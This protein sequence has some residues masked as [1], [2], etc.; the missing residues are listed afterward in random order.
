[1]ENGPSGERQGIVGVGQDDLGAISDSQPRT[2]GVINENIEELLQDLEHHLK[3]GHKYDGF[4][5]VVDKEAANLLLYVSKT[6]QKLWDVVI[7]INQNASLRENRDRKYGEELIPIVARLL[8]ALPNR[9]EEENAF[10]HVYQSTRSENFR[11]PG[12]WVDDA[13]QFLCLDVIDEGLPQNGYYLYFSSL[14]QSASE[15]I[16]RLKGLERSHERASNDAAEE[17]ILK[18]MHKIEVQINHSFATAEHQCPELLNE[19]R[20]SLGVEASLKPLVLDGYAEFLERLDSLLKE[21]VLRKNKEQL[22]DIPILQDGGGGMQHPAIFNLENL[23]VDENLLRSCFVAYCEVR[24][25]L[26]KAYH[27]GGTLRTIDKTVGL[28]QAIERALRAPGFLEPL[29]ASGCEVPGALAF[30][31]SVQPALRYTEQ[32]RM[33]QTYYPLCEMGNNL[34]T[35][36]LVI[37][38]YLTSSVEEEKEISSELNAIPQFK[39]QVFLFL[40]DIKALLQEDKALE[41]ARAIDDKIEALLSNKKSDLE[42][43][44]F[45]LTLKALGELPHFAAQLKKRIGRLNKLVNIANSSNRKEDLAS[46]PARIVRQLSFNLDDFYGKTEIVNRLRKALD[47]FILFTSNLEVLEGRAPDEVINNGTLIDGPPGAG[48]TFLV[49]CMANEYELPIFRVSVEEFEKTPNQALQA[50]PVDRYRSYSESSRQREVPSDSNKRELSTSDIIAGV[51]RRMEQVKEASRRGPVL[52]L[53]DDC[54][55]LAPKRSEARSSD[56]VQLTS[57][58]LHVVPELRRSYPNVFIAATTNNFRA[59]DEA[60]YRDGRMDILVTLDEPNVDDRKAMI[61]GTLVLETGDCNLSEDQLTQ[62]AEAATSLLPVSLK[63]ALDGPYRWRRAKRDRQE[64]SFQELLASVRAK[65]E[66]RKLAHL[67]ETVDSE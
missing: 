56:Q 3:E 58:M 11:S 42:I 2:N 49:E 48:K 35:L 26:L 31:I 13:R 38:H 50:A 30:D 57:Y 59:L 51:D 6:L 61:R 20:D 52:L 65:V 63:K 39:E 8:Q 47:D 23:L 66:D 4:S 46:L 7:D 43:C 29:L 64:M 25:I 19:V 10:L 17:Q 22:L 36:S 14:S 18:E 32:G 44:G 15:L 41:A 24:G 1:M 37:K 53:L 55:A 21:A 60:F 5:Q 28:K 45:L 54:E 16:G 33:M 9:S 12:S 34:R 62:L 67:R 40:R 27:L